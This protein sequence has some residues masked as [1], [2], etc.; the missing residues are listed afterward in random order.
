MSTMS[1]IEHWCSSQSI[2]FL[3]SNQFEWKSQLTESADNMEPELNGRISV[4]TITETAEFIG[5]VNW[6]KLSWINMCEFSTFIEGM[7]FYEHAC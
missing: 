1:Q 7:I 6:T 2:I 5:T 3:M 4:C